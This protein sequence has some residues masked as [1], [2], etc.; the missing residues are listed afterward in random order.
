LKKS[1]QIFAQKYKPPYQIILSANELNLKN[2]KKLYPL[3]LAGFL[4]KA[5]G[6]NHSVHPSPVS[7]NPNLDN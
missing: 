1:L 3:Y 2:T 7:F 6:L 5:D 4:K